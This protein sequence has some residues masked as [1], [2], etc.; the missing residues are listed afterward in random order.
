MKKERNAYSDEL[1][2]WEVKVLYALNCIPW[3]SSSFHTNNG[4]E[5]PAGIP[6]FYVWRPPV[7]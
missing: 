6:I 3:F 4:T 7:E 2:E 5:T 1:C